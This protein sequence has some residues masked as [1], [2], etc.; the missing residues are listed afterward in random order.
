MRALLVFCSVAALLGGCGGDP[1]ERGKLDLEAV[2]P[3]G[4]GCEAPAAKDLMTGPEM[5]PGRVCGDCHKPDGEALTTF[6]AAGTVYGARMG[7]CDDP[8]LDGV[9]VEILD[10][11]G[12]VQETMMTNA[13]GNFFTSAP[14]KLPMRVRLS[15]A[16]KT[17]VMTSTMEIATCATCHQAEP[18]SGAPGRVY[19]E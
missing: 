7:A 12:A 15:Q 18:Q 3:A 11:D 1:F 13:V 6:T 8:G 4:A 17:A 14:I 5:L 2:P 16:G 10:M 9:T 19:L